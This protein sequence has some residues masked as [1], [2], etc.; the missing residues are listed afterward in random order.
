MCGE[1][2]L[3]MK[4]RTALRGKHGYIRSRMTSLCAQDTD[5]RG[6]ETVDYHVDLSVYHFPTSELRYWYSR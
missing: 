3:Y 6:T 2:S 5:P 4:V 1:R